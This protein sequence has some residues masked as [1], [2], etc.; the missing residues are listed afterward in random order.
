MV[1]ICQLGSLQS[2]HHSGLISHEPISPLAFSLFS[3]LSFFHAIFSPV[4]IYRSL[5]HSK[6]SISILNISLYL[7]PLL[8]K[9]SWFTVVPG[10]LCSSAQCS[11]F[12]AFSHVFIFPPCVCS[13]FFLSCYAAG[14]CFS[15]I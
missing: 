13:S 3:L 14:K 8:P 10:Q 11:N 7:S 5:F 2:G 15:M 12:L 6:S 4:T 9:V 1:S